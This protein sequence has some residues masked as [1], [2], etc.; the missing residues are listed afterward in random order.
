MASERELSQFGLGSVTMSPAAEL[1]DEALLQ[2]Q[3][4]L[5]READYVETDL[6]LRVLLTSLG[7][8]I[9]VGSSALGLM[10]RRDLDITV[11]CPLLD[12]EAVADLGA[13]LG[14]H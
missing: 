13:R 2:R 1:S 9:R 8:P 7:D 4:A 12:A 14:R 3:G 11:I 6:G 5:Q 10:V